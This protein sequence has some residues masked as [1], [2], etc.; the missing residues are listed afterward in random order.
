MVCVLV[1]AGV[2][3][4]SSGH[5]VPSADKPKPPEPAAKGK[6]LSAEEIDTLIEKVFCR[7]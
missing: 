1:L 6:E 2:S 5:K 4:Q 3:A 7:E